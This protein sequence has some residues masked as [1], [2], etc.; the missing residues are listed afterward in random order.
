[1]FRERGMVVG[2]SGQRLLTVCVFVLLIRSNE[3]EGFFLKPLWEFIGV[4][5]LT[6]SPNGLKK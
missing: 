2:R 4:W 1:M 6:A 3:E 5:V